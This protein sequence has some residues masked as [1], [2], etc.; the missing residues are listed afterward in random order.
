MATMK[1]GTCGAADSIAFCAETGAPICAMCTVSCDVCGAPL[2]RGREQ[3]TSTGRK[4]CSSCMA[5]RN[6]RRRAKK[7]ELRREAAEKKREAAPAAAPRGGVSFE[8]LM[9]DD[10]ALSG[11]LRAVKREEAPARAAAQSETPKPSGTAFQ[12][13]VSEGP[14]AYQSASLA[15]DAGFDGAI[16][17]DESANAFGLE[18]RAKEGASRL[19][20]G[21]IDDN[22]PILTGSGYQPQ[23]K[24]VYLAAFAFFG[25]AA[26]IFWSVVPGIRDVMFPEQHVGA[27]FTSNLAPIATDTNALRNTSNIGQFDLFSQ[28][29]IFFIAWFLVLAYTIGFVRIVWSVG[30][31]LTSSFFANRRLKK[32]EEYAKKHGY[33]YPG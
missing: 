16:E 3:L 24:L 8:D 2:S 7:E 13:L 31:S 32:A 12:D 18:G 14:K 6:T 9:R 5:A 28:A 29:P 1:C 25:I 10:P 27:Q 11:N 19:A 33:S 30:R 21:P 23:S 22:R 20:L 26:A 4:L 17:G 15:R